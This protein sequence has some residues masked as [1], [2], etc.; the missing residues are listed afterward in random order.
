MP[1]SV[2][3]NVNNQPTHRSRQPFST[4][5][6]PLLKRRR[7][8]P[9]HHRLRPAKLTLHRPHQLRKTR[10]RRLL[11]TQIHQ[12]HIVQELAL[13]IASKPVHAPRHVP[14][15]KP[16]RS[17]ARSWTPPDL[18]NR[19]IPTKPG[20]FLPSLLERVKQV[21]GRRMQPNNRSAQPRLDHACHL[22]PQSVD[23]W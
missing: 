3:R 8:D 1:L 17:H 6:A 2:F 9:P 7:Q 5:Y 22:N 10:S 16:N 18:L 19:Q 21:R 20:Q 13:Q 15:L 11:R 14:H 23:Q 12:L 4:H